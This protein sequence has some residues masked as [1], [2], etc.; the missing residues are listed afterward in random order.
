MPSSRR[1]LR[2]FPAALLACVT[3]ACSS[4]PRIEMDR[5]SAP[6]IEKL[7]LVNVP[8]APAPN[9]TNS[10]GAAG[11]FGHVGA[12]AVVSVNASHGKTYAAAVA[13][14][15]A[16]LAPE[17]T[18]ALADSLAKVG[19]LVTPAEG[20]AKVISDGEDVD[21]SGVATPGDAI[22]AVW[23]TS[24]GYYSPPRVSFYQP[25][26]VAKAKLIDARSRGALY[27][28]T[29]SVGCEL[30]ARNAVH[31]PGGEHYR[32]GSFDEL[33]ASTQES[34]NGIESATQAVVSHIRDDLAR[35]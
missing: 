2:V 14:R 19:Y 31:I 11:A 12:L 3:A 8:R 16:A 4:V 32:Y 18:T 21:V 17:T 20:E 26:V 29:F 30:A 35:R 6:R 27:F 22:L 25:C 34:A 5:S 33:M 23:F 28:K 24:V 7:A 9:V 13:D 1:M 10:G 15:S